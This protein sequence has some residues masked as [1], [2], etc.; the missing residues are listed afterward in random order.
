MF[1]QVGEQ[2]L[3]CD[4]AGGGDDSVRHPVIAERADHLASAFADPPH[5]VLMLAHHLRER[6][7]VVKQLVHPFLRR[8]LL[9]LLHPP[10]DSRVYCPY[11]LG[12]LLVGRA[13]RP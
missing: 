9:V 7:G 4:A 10:N 3:V 2:G 8:A 1:S 11:S 12:Y 13:G 5:R 6:G